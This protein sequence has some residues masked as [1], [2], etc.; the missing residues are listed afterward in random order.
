M[1]GGNGKILMSLGLFKEILSTGRFKDEIWLNWR[2]ES[3]LN[4]QLPE[5][6]LFAKEFGIKTKLST[7]TVAPPLR[8]RAWTQR[9]LSGLD[10]L[11]VC[12]DGYDQH[13]L[14]NY[15]V[16]AKWDH[17]LE[18]LS[19]IGD[20]KTD[21]R[22]EMRVLMFKHNDGKEDFY[23]R[24]AQ[25]NNIDAIRWA[26]PIINYKMILDDNDVVTW[27]S[28]NPKYHRYHEKDGRWHFNR[29]ENCNPHFICS[30][31]GTIHACGNDYNL[32]YPVG[33]I[34]QDDWKTILSN[35]EKL[36]PKMM[37]RSLPFCKDLCCLTKGRIDFLEELK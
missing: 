2:G 29:A 30:V 22:R 4:S 11:M 18:A 12:V 8:R 26:R 21:C 33:H 1:S 32:E 35:F 10:C 14:E 19:I 28:D 3:C 25:E 6:V 34:L 37:K 13:S 7:N 20:A 24:L 23:R 31:M 9:L 16:N 15:R 5:M 17:L 36:K 27:L